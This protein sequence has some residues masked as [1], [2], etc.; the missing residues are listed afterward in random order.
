MTTT[1]MYHGK[2]CALC[3][4]GVQYANTV[5]HAKNRV[6]IIRKP[7]LHVH[8]M[9]VG[10]E[11]LKLNL[12]AKCKRSIRKATPKVATKPVVVKEV[13]APKKTKAVSVQK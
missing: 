10:G 9:V 3:G 6:H 12:C 1:E 7:N 11:K 4:K 5:S 8:R 13:A 2:N